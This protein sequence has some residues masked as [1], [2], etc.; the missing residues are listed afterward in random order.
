M[1]RTQWGCV[2]SPDSSAWWRKFKPGRW[3][4]TDKV[5]IGGLDITTVATANQYFRSNLPGGGR[6]NPACTGVQ[7]KDRALTPIR[8]M[9]N[10]PGFV[11]T[12]GPVS[13]D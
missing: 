7:R 6:Q 2:W 3:T 1:S 5:R 11:L 13:H 4:S 10:R 8:T 9:A 12:S